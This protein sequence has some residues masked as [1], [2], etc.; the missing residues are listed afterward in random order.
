MLT[1]LVFYRRYPARNRRPLSPTEPNFSTLSQEWLRIRDT[2]VRPMLTP[3]TPP[4]R[5]P[6]VPAPPG[7]AAGRAALPL[8]RAVIGV[9]SSQ[10]PLEELQ[11]KHHDYPAIDLQVAE[12]TPIYA[13]VGGTVELAGE[14]GGFGS[15]AVYIRDDNGNKWIY[16]HGSA[17]RVTRGQRVPAGHHIADSGNEGKSSGPHLH[18]QI[19]DAKGE[20]R[21]PQPFLAALWNGQ[22]PPPVASLPTSG[23]SY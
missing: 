11:D 10:A 12:G 7:A 19:V 20:N 4:M 3:Q 17:H 16:G 23:C 14:A 13:V 5:G 8:P 21:C 15:H 1:D 22:V 9:R 6:Y 18:L 2:Q